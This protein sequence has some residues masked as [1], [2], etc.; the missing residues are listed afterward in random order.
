MMLDLRHL[1]PAR[2]QS[3]GDRTP[4]ERLAMHVDA[5][6]SLCGDVIASY[7]QQRSGG[8]H[9]G[10]GPDVSTYASQ[11]RQWSRYQLL[12]ANARADHPG[13]QAKQERGV[14]LDTVE[15][16]VLRQL[17]HEAGKTEEPHGLMRPDQWPTV[18]YSWQRESAAFHGWWWWHVGAGRHL[19]RELVPDFWAPETIAPEIEKTVRG[20]LTRQHHS[21]AQRHDP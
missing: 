2:E 9:F 5:L 12:L 21:R 8:P 10:F 3:G 20:A 19:D 4:R 1:P 14:P 18:T 11:L 7:E 17:E 6:S 16:A 13:L 15:T